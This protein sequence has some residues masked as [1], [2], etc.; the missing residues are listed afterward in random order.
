M[1]VNGSLAAIRSPA[2]RLY[3]MGNA[4][5]LQATWIQRITI[6]W[7]AWDLSASASFVGWI[8]FL[9]FAPTLV[10]G[11]VFGAL[12]DRSPV[13]RAATI[14]QAAMFA[15]AVL[16]ALTH[17]AGALGQTA[18]AGFALA[19][20]IVTSAHHPIRMSLAP[21]LVPVS[22][23]GSVANLASINFNLARSVGPAI[24]GFLIA[25]FGIGTAM[26]VTAAC[27]L[28]YQIV[29]PFLRTRDL[30]LSSPPETTLL[31][32]LA[33][34]FRFAWRTGR[35]RAILLVTLIA[36]VIGRGMLELLPLIADGIFARGPAGLGLLTSAAG[37]GALGAA[38]MVLML[39]V[40]RPGE[41]PPAG[42]VASFASI[43][44]CGVLAISQSW[45]LTVAATGLLGG[46][47]TVM[48]ISMQAALQPALPDDYRGRVMSL[49]VMTGVGG[50]AL[51]ALFLGA[52]AEIAGLRAGTLL[53]CA[54]GVALLVLAARRGR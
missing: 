11:P 50:S 18:L 53:P 22:A 10:S 7:L 9:G 47:A 15:L 39:P 2:F 14:S 8:A 12:V 5:A 42:L 25:N 1:K 21:L 54:A 44:L 28:P 29:L 4:F 35:I 3:L 33:S 16:L 19:I 43:G 23:V 45:P 26:W 30:S 46:T 24:G 36:A 52:M 20:G 27:L 37:I 34:G 38:L 6:A 51:G 32:G 40:P 31:R 49:W 41:V 48:G 13:R 17:W